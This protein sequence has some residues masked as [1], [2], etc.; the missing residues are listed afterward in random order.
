MT[1]SKSATPE[2][3]QLL[4]SK[5]E[6]AGYKYDEEKREVVKVGWK[7]K[8]DEE[9]DFITYVGDIEHDTYQCISM[10]DEK[11]QT[12]NCFKP[13][14]LDPEKVKARFEEF[15]PRLRKIIT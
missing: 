11:I 8:E 3:R 1:S 5:L 10:D 9:F 6:E 4:L 2:Q 13:G 14:T 15:L 7:P 12:G